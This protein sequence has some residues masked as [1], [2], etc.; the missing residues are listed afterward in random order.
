MN[1]KIT[2]PGDLMGV[3][4]LVFFA[5]VLVK[6]SVEE[7][8]LLAHWEYGIAHVDKVYRSGKLEMMIGYWYDAGGVRYTDGTVWDGKA[9]SGQ[10]YV[11]RYGSFA[12]K[13]NEFLYELPVPDSIVEAHGKKWQ[14]FLRYAHYHSPYIRYNAVI[15]QP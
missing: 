15:D 5:L 6:C 2:K 9:R 14:K 13:G 1:W 11:V 7:I 4:C 3:A 12:P 8:S 10:R